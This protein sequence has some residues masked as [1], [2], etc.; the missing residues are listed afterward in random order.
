VA[1]HILQKGEIVPLRFTLSTEYPFSMDCNAQPWMAF[2]LPLC[3]GKNSIADL[4][5]QAKENGWIVQQTP[6]EE[7]C[8]LI[9]TLISGGFLRTEEFKLPAAAG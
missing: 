4:F 2:L 3:N 9:A 7:F 6:R 5:Q 1:R 8:R